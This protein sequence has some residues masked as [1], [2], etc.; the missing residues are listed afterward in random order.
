[1]NEEIASKVLDA[2]TEYFTAGPGPWR[3]RL[4]FVVEMM[5]ET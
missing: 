2:E 1:M 4:A 3:E 5:R